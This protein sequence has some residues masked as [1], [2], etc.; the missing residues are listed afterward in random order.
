VARFN[1]PM[2][3]MAAFGV[4]HSSSSR[5]MLYYHQKYNATVTRSHWLT[6]LSSFIRIGGGS[7]LP[8]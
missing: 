8:Y 3:P 7:P 1:S 4:H 5:E 2:K 6:V